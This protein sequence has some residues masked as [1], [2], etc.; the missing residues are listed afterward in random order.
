MKKLIRRD[1]LQSQQ[2]SIK[3]IVDKGDVID[4]KYTENNGRKK[5]KIEEAIQDNRLSAKKPAAESFCLDGVHPS[6]GKNEKDRIDEE[7]EINEEE[8]EELEEEEE[9]DEAEEESSEEDE[10]DEED[11]DE[12]DEEEEEVEVIAMKKVSH[13]NGS[14]SKSQSLIESKLRG[15]SCS[16]SNHVTS[17]HSSVEHKKRKLEIEIK[18]DT[19]AVQNKKIMLNFPGSPDRAIGVVSE[20][21]KASA[22]F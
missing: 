18:I 13:I 12:E 1:R 4:D 15:E 2:N 7:V 10:D 8:D 22:Y 5:E 6:S 20:R 9:E 14:Q 11:D 16:S 17:S 21:Q 19:N 3:N